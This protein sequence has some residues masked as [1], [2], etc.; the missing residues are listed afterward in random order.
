MK[1][2]TV[3]LFLLLPAFSYA[4]YPQLPA[5]V[6][7]SFNKDFPGGI[8]NSWTGNNNYNF[9]YDWDNDAY[10]DDFSFDGYP[11]EYAYT[12]EPFF[13]DMGDDV[14][15][16]YDDD[17]DFNYYVPDDYQLGYPAP[18]SQYQLNFRYKQLRMSGVFKPNGTLLLAKARVVLLPGTIVQA[19]KNTF[20]GKFIR[21]AH[22]KE[23]LMTP[24]YLHNPVYRVKVFVKHNGYSIL[25]IDSKGHVISNNH[26]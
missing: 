11:D 15:F 19:I 3:F 13:D 10:F 12:D 17:L 2:L 1:R 21:V 25:K 4:Q 6:V 14:P 7:N 9:T 22:A 26:Y 24:R 23:I 16:Y 5:A 20:K 8:I 18:P